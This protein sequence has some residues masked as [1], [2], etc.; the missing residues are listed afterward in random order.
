M[1]KPLRDG[2]GRQK[3][4]IRIDTIATGDDD[5]VGLPR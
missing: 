4:V 2:N 1:C 3:S 5:I